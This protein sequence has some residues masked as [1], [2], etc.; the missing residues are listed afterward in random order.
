MVEKNES[1]ATVKGAIRNDVLPKEP[2][3]TNE[4][5]ICM[6]RNAIETNISYDDERKTYYVTLNWGKNSEG[7]YEKTT[8]TTGNKREA[9]KILAEHKKKM[10]AGTAMPPVKETLSAAVESYVEYKS[11]KLAATTIYGYRNILKNHVE[12]YFKERKIQSISVQDIQNYIVAKSQSG[13]SMSSIKKHLE[14]LKGYIFQDEE[15][16]PDG[17]SIFKPGSDIAPEVSKYAREVLLVE[18]LYEQEEYGDKELM[19]QLL[20][21][22]ENNLDNLSE[23]DLLAMKAKCLELAQKW[24]K[25]S[26]ELRAN[27]RLFAKKDLDFYCDVYNRMEMTVSSRAD[28]IE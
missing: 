15:Y 23:D 18:H 24:Q 27:A 7:K 2:R 8:V 10:A 26:R 3:L 16:H 25:A 20:D 28:E 6:A 13:L 14:L 19:H 17:I 5:R 21:E 4:G 11:L 1:C 22:R 9:R 12:P